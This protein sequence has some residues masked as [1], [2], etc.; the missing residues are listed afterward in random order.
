[1]LTMRWLAM[2]AL[3]AGCATN[4]D[5]DHFADAL[6]D[7][8]CTYFVRCGVATSATECRAFYERVAV[9]NPSTNAALDDGK[10]EYHAD[11][12]QN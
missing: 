2:I 1:M 9:A 5:Y 10:I 6:I 7:A 8:R 4:I 12:A 11:V 3:V